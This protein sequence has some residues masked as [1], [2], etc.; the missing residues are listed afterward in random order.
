[1]VV[2]WCEVVPSALKQGRDVFGDLGS[3]LPLV[4]AL[5]N[6]FDAEGVL[7]PGRFAGGI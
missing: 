6:S 4:R 7:N 1:M 5:K 3:R 2:W